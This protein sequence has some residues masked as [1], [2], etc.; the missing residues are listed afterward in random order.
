MAMVDHNES[1]SAT[2]VDADSMHYE[3]W[4]SL[5]RNLLAD[6]DTESEALTAV[7]DL[8]ASNPPEMANELVLVWRDGA[9]GGTLAEGSGLSVRAQAANSERTRLS[10]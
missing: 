6:F 7:R 4:D 9:Q 1:D 5:S 8:L 3:L 2:P 10:R